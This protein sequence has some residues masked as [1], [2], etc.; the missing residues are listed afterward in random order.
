MMIGWILF[1]DAVAHLVK[2]HGIPERE[3]GGKIVTAARHGV[4]YTQGR[5][6][7][8]RGRPF[9][10][11]PEA[12]IGMD[13][14]PALSRLCTP[15]P[16]TVVQEP[17]LK[18]PN[19]FVVEIHAGSLEAWVSGQPC[20]SAPHIE[21]PVP[22]EL[23]TSPLVWREL[24]FAAALAEE[25][26]ATSAN[27]ESAPPELVAESGP[28]SKTH[29]KRGPPPLKRTQVKEAM[30]KVGLQEVQRWSEEALVA[31]FGTSRTTCR[32]AKKELESEIV[33]DLNSD[34]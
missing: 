11:A 8:A 16:D 4:L 30:R 10:I 12:W 34:K 18:S 29:K 5:L 3:A 13:P 19:V 23:R 21:Q 33:G 24:H 1:A 25:A 31:Q 14:D 20:P 28:S 15:N 27:S 22:D 26:P 17:F 6:Y 7:H 2:E 9:I 32:D